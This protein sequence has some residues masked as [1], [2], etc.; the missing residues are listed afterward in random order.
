MYS[1]IEDVNLAIPLSFKSQA[2]APRRESENIAN[3]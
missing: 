1:S 3:I 2:S